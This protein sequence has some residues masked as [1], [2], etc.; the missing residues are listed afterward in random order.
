MESFSRSDKISVVFC[1][2]TLSSGPHKAFIES[3]EA[4]VP[5]LDEK[6]IEHHMVIE[7][8]NPYISH[9]RATMLRKALSK[10]PN[11]IVFLDHDIS[12]KP[13]DL[14][15]LIET[16]GDVVAGTYRFKKDKE[17]YMGTLFPADDNKPVVREDGCVKA[18]WIPA[19]FLKITESA[20]S[21]FMDGYPELVYGPKYR[22][23]VDL[24]NHGAYK[25]MWYGED[26]AFSRNWNSL[27]EEIWIVPDLDIAHHSED[28]VYKG[29]FHEFLLRQPGGSRHE[30]H[31][32]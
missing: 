25:G 9:A 30:E 8:Q 4:S 5:L 26:Y 17:Q 13:Q 16:E 24:F 1:C 2:P 21:K 32:S 7:V 19:G 28:K 29:N 18:E 3:M 27:G 20:L 22:P 10:D 15:D 6:G 11:T 14:V 31:N 23:G 12:W